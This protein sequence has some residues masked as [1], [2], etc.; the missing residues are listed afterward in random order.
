MSPAS[1]A[2]CRRAPVNRAFQTLAVLAAALFA[3]VSGIRAAPSAVEVRVEITE[4][5]HAEAVRLGIEWLD[6]VSLAERDIAGIVKVGTIDRLTPLQAQLNFLIQEGA[7]ELLA[8]PNLLTDSGTTASFH[9]G[10]QIPYA[11]TSSLGTSHVEFKPY[12]VALKIKP[13]IL[14]DGL[15]KMKIDASVSEPDMSNA[16]I[17]AGNAVP[18]LLERDVSAW[19]TVEPGATTVLAG[20][21]Q[22][23]QEETDRGVPFLRR[24]PLAGRLFRWTQKSRRR[25][26]IV[27]FVTPVIAQR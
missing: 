18:A 12:G 25:S 22:S 3:A 8:N 27:I 15:I 5:N 14:K 19:V 6:R 23:V 17:V 26:S 21:V 24:I 20:L 4:V 1:K 7:A 2:A 9:A 13:T 11:T 16:V 10:G